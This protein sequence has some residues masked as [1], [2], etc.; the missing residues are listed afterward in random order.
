MARLGLIV[1]DPGHFHA[2]LAQKEMYPNVAERVH[3]YAPVGPDLVDYLARIARF[4][5]RAEAPTRWR[6]EIHTGN[7]FL[8]RLT[9]EKPGDAAIFAGR[10]HEKIDMIARA[11]EAGLCVL[12]DKPM[13]VRRDQLPALSGVLDRAAAKGLVLLDMMGGRQ[14]MNRSLTRLIHV[15]PEL[16][17]EQIAGTRAEPGVAM[18]SVHHL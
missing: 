2:A 4:N 9:R 5:T 16:F 13:I 6:L 18:T 8:D 14:E 7:D 11:V 1:V 3:V 12:A 10:N 17:G 15:D